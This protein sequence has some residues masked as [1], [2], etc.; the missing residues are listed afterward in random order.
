MGIGRVNTGGGGSGGTLVVTAPAGV[1]VTAT[2]DDKTYTRTANAEGAATF[3]GLSSGTWMLSISD[4]SHEPSTPVPVEIIADYTQTLAFF[5]AMINVTYPA[6]STCT[7]TLGEVQLVSTAAEDASGKCVFTVPSA[8]TWEVKSTAND[9]S[10]RSDSENVSVTTN[11]QTKSVALS[12]WSGYLYYWG[13]MKTDVSGGWTA[14]AWRHNENYTGA[15]P[16]ITD[17]NSGAN[18]SIGRDSTEWLSGVYTTASAIDL[19]AYTTLTFCGY[20]EWTDQYS[21]GRI[22]AIPVSQSHWA[23]VPQAYFTASTSAITTTLDVSSLSGKYY[24]G[25][26]VYCSSAEAYVVMGSLHL[27]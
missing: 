2:K 4:A 18:I 17:S 24:L 12:Y 13:D 15:T 10:D 9:G 16:K 19:T 3:K 11:G 7:C 25:V 23:G 8:G 22:I 27:T 26:G 5:S 14:R 20:G 6:G 1:T 21:S